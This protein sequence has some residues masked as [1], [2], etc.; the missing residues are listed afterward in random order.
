M[1]QIAG[2]YE[3]LHPDSLKAD[4]EISYL[5]HFKP[6]VIYLDRFQPGDTTFSDLDK[7]KTLFKRFGT[8]H[9]IFNG[10]SSNQGIFKSEI[11]FMF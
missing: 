5:N 7:F 9:V 2:N 3:G 1:S 8:R 11:Y 6:G 10:L 4:P